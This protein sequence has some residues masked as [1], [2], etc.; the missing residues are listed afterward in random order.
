MD[1]FCIH[2]KELQQVEDKLKTCKKCGLID[3]EGYFFPPEVSKYFDSYMWLCREHSNQLTLMI[4]NFI[5]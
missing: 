2:Q 1:D 3:H 5:K 4:N